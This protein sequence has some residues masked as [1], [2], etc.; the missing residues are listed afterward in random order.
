LYLLRSYRFSVRLIVGSGGLRMPLRDT[1]KNAFL[2][3][4]TTTVM[5]AMS[6]KALSRAP[7]TAAVC[8]A[9]AARCK[10]MM[11]VTFG[12]SRLA[13]TIDQLYALTLLVLQQWCC[14]AISNC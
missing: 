1:V 7:A 2:L 8:S 14:N 3:I 10:R 6:S 4:V 9:V 12:K 11:Q 5:L 13:Y